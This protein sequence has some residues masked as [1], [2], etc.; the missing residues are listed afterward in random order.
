MAPVVISQILTGIKDRRPGT[1]V[2]ADFSVSVWV[3]HVPVPCRHVKE[4]EGIG[5][6]P[7]LN[8]HASLLSSPSRANRIRGKAMQALRPPL[9]LLSNGVSRTVVRDRPRD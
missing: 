7:C 5:D 2:P 3:H 6:S 1:Q 9:T 8:F 4:G